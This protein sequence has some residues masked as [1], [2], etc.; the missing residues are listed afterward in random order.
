MTTP[1]TTAV[2]LRAGTPEDAGAVLALFD[3]AV[4][5]LVERGRSDQW[6]SDSFSSREPGRQTVDRFSRSD[7]F[8]VAVDGAG[9]PGER[10]VGAVVV[11][12]GP[13]SYV[14]P[15]QEPERYVQL[16][17]TSRRE[18]GRDLGGLLVEH[19]RGV[20]RRDGVELLRVDCF[21]GGEQRLVRWYEGQGFVRS[22]TVDVNGWPCQVLEQRVR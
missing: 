10:V 9:T 2:T 13:P 8:V 1:P 11:S 19:A 12:P 3:E 14:E 6:G 5:W 16:L 22:T 15:V 7:G 17:I 4:A 21:G 18:K 20:C